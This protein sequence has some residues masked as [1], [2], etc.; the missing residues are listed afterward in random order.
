LRTLRQLLLILLALMGLTAPVFAQATGTAAPASI[1]GI[2]ADA[3]GAPLA[4]VTVTL[5]GPTNISTVTSDDGRYT[6]SGIAPGLYAVTALKAGYGG[7]SQTDYAVASGTATTLNVT[8]VAATFSS[9]RE[10]GRI[11][12]NAGQSRF[13]T[14]AAS[15]ATVTAQ[16]FG[17]QSQ[18]QVA[19]ILNQTPGIVSSLP[20]GVNNAS[21]GAITFPNIRGALGFETAALID[22]HPLSVGQYGDYVTTFLNSFVLQSVEV[23]KGPGASSPTISRAIGGT[24]N[25]RTIDPTPHQTATVT[26]G[27]DS[28]GG[29]FSNFGY[30][31]TFGKLGI[32][33]DYA[34]NGTPGPLSD[35]PYYMTLNSGTYLV[36]DSHGNP[37]TL[38]APTVTNSNPPG[39]YNT[40]NE[41]STELLFS[42]AR[43]YTTFTNKNE[44][45][46]L[47]YAFSPSTTLSAS[48]LGSQTYADQNGNNGNLNST[49]FTPGPGYNGSV[50][51]GVQ[52]ILDPDN[53]GVPAWEINNEPLFS[54][55]LRTSIG[56][57]SFLARYYTASI[58]RLQYGSNHDP[59]GSAGF[60]ALIYGGGTADGTPL[61]TGA[62]QFGKP[63]TVT[64]PSRNDP[65]GIG[66]NAYYDSAE[67]DKLA[68]YSAEYDH[69]FAGLAGDMVSLSYDA[70]HSRTH[71]YSLGSSLDSVPAGS[72]QDTNTLLLR[73]IFNVGKLNITESNYL[74][75]FRS[76]F[77]VYQN[78]FTPQQFLSFQDQD[79]WHFDER[80]GLEFRST[81]NLS[82]RASA[83]SAVAP[84]YLGALVA[85]TFAPQLCGGFFTPCPSGGGQVAVSQASNP[86]LKAE[87]SFGYDIGGDF[88]FGDGLT[89]LTADA[90]LTNL[91][92]QLIQSTFLNGT[93]TIVGSGTLPLYTTSYTNVS[94]ARYEGVELGIRRDPRVGFG[95]TVQ[96]AILRAFPY[97][98]SPSFYSGSGG[99]LTTNLG[100]VPNINFGS[101]QTVSNQAIPYSQGYGEVRVRTRHGDLLSFG[102]TY[103]GTN[104]SLNVPAFFVANAT[105]RAVVAKGSFVQFSVDNLF[106][107][108]GGSL[109]TEYVGNQQPLVNGLSYASNANVIGPR[110]V[111][112]S[113]TTNIG[114]R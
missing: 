19:R 107:A 66:G 101:H 80:I 89:V 51:G 34:V 36:S 95:Y 7:V 47:R 103:Y 18:P 110:V 54:A 59:N 94:Q 6:F 46:K 8:L 16:T 12:V 26:L 20:G 53:F 99:A 100:V 52:P 105:A 49:L 40:R 76:H 61:F 17:D 79:L 10:I 84:P 28:Y 29:Q 113:F 4:G 72:S 114:S 23:I 108:L 70:N 81:R 27:I 39:Q 71:S 37:I 11:S 60:S 22:G 86:N 55:E 32:L 92:N 21:S 42:G 62:D 24:V 102:E 98:L 30:S 67:E 106:N 104:N 83:G 15:V 69:P 48:F 65:S 33:L 9:L 35:A 74:T 73:G 91:H 31:N 75:D 58:S 56:N 38:P 13:N 82:I 1:T 85:N 63:Y 14:T 97:N 77:G 43:E 112:F 88:R 96:G 111:R 45:I 78:S 87:T 57:D 109:P 25:F 90:Y 41:A 64:L 50:A 44:L 2:A 68:G 93:A 3:N 5:S